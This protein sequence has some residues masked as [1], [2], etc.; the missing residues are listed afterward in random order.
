M[1]PISKTL[2]GLDNFYMVGQW[3]QAGGGLP[4][5]VMTAREVMKRICKQAGRG[6]KTAK[7]LR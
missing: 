2:P 6:F 7:N 5:G 3:V 1:K 4:S